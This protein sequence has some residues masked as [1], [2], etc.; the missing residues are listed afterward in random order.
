MSI[1]TDYFKLVQESTDDGANDKAKKA[2]QEILVKI[3]KA[4]SDAGYKL[5]DDKKNEDAFINNRKKFMTNGNNLCIAGIGKENYDA[6]YNIIA[7]TIKGTDFTISKDNYWT[8]FLSVK[9][10]S[11][12]YTE[13]ANGSVNLMTI[14]NSIVPY[15]ESANEDNSDVEEEFNIGNMLPQ[16]GSTEGMADP[17]SV[18]NDIKKVN[19]KNKELEGITLP[20]DIQI[21]SSITEYINDSNQTYNSFI[22]ESVSDVATKVGKKVKLSFKTRKILTQRAILRTRLLSAQRFHADPVKINDIKQALIEK[23]KEV[24]ALKQGANKE[25]CDEIN[26]LSDDL[27][28]EIKAKSLKKKMKNKDDEVSNSNSIENECDNTSKECGEEYKAESTLS[29]KEELQVKLEKA[30]ERNDIDAIVA[31][32]NKLKYLSKM[33]D[34]EYTCEAANIDSEIKEVID[35]L[36]AKGYKTKY[37]SAGH[38]Q[39]RKKSDIDDNGVYYGKLYSDARIMFDSDYEF[40]KAP[41]YWVWKTVD[42]KDYLDIIPIPYNPKDGTPEEAFSKWKVNYMGT[43]RTWVDNLPTESKTDGKTE[44]KDTKDRVK[45]I[46]A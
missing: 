15:Y 43:L 44:I 34:Q 14:G 11:D 16:C 33:E 13:S 24:R 17:N 4:V 6:V 7:K 25:T 21:E 1:F 12:I 26:R 10:D 42:D 20:D 18:I 36:N 46:E 3:K 23:E 5:R 22:D 37:S 29:K 27:Y 30:M 28:N 32:E 19:N 41:K 9:D 8:L 45:T 31:Y 39:L 38:T 2:K 35:K 40:P